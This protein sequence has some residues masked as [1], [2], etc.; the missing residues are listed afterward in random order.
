[1]DVRNYP[2]KISQSW[3]VAS[4]RNT[5]SCIAPSKISHPVSSAECWFDVPIGPSVL[6]WD[7]RSQSRLLQ[8]QAHSDLITCMRLSPDQGCVFQ[9]RTGLATDVH[10]SLNWPM[11]TRAHIK[12]R[13]PWFS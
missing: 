11:C 8:F 1:M 10:G 3:G 2:I 6:R 12:C 5:S 7:V 13:T 4:A 9:K